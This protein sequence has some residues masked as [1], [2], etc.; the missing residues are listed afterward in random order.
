MSCYMNI[1]NFIPNILFEDMKILLCVFE[2]LPQM[3]HCA[4]TIVVPL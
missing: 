1:N 2:H 4:Q 3:E